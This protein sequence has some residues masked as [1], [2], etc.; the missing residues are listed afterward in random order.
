MRCDVRWI[1]QAIAAAIHGQGWLREDLQPC[2]KRTCQ[3]T[4]Y[5]H[6]VPER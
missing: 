4:Q 6:L 3:G 2:E 1:G 5:Q